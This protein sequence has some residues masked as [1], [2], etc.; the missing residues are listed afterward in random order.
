MYDFILILQF[1]TCLVLSSLV[2]ADIKGIVREG[3]LSVM[4]KKYLLLHKVPILKLT[5]LQKSYPI[6]DLNG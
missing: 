3:L 5:R 6:H 1:Q 4:M 2:Q